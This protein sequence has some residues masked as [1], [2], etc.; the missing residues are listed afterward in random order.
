MRDVVLGSG[1]MEFMNGIDEIA[2]FF[3]VVI[4]LVDRNREIYIS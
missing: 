3:D 2:L 4:F 1:G